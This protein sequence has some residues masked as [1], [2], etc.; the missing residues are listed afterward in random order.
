[1]EQGRKPRIGLSINL[2]CKVGGESRGH[3]LLTESGARS[4]LNVLGQKILVYPLRHSIAKRKIL[5]AEA[6]KS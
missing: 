1:M 4:E 5:L 6:S 3:R 2:D